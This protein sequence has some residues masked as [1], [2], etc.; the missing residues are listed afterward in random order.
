MAMP[1]RVL[2]KRKSKDLANIMIRTMSTQGVSKGRPIT[3][4]GKI[5]EPRIGKEEEEDEDVDIDDT[6]EIATLAKEVA[7]HM[8]GFG[9]SPNFCI[10]MRGGATNLKVK[11]LSDFIEESMVARAL[12]DLSECNGSV[13]FPL[14]IDRVECGTENIA[15]YSYTTA[16]LPVDT[17]SS[18]LARL[19]VIGDEDEFIRAISSLFLQTLL[20]IEA[21]SEEVVIPLGQMRPS[22]VYVGSFECDPHITEREFERPRG[23]ASMFIPKEDLEDHH[24]IIDVANISRVRSP[25]NALNGQSLDWFFTPFHI[26]VL[27]PVDHGLEEYNKW[28]SYMLTDTYE[29]D[30][31]TIRYYIQ[32][33]MPSRYDHRDKRWDV[34][35]SDDDTEWD[36]LSEFLVATHRTDATVRSLIENNLFQRFKTPISG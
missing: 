12:S 23:L 7:I 34:D 32:K 33:S 20:A 10:A 19:A 2:L 24:A 5:R 14:V 35:A 15:S 4:A 26:G 1:G 31:H 6:G 9:K 13:G 8:S 25:S 17:I 11:G 30:M 3:D 29:R 18:Y 28:A 27:S 16:P 21:A 36:C 22:M